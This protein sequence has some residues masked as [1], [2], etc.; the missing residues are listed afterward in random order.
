[1]T[2]Q[3]V[4]SK[5]IKETLEIIKGLEVVVPAGVEIAAD[6]KVSA[7]DIKPVIEVVK[8]YD[9][10]V[11]AIK[12]GGEAIGEAKDYDTLELAQIGGAFLEVVKKSKEA[13]ARGK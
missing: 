11:A 12:D 5:G 3:K 8:Q 10:V 1:M 9:V 7:K 2:E 4:E 6:G 13:Y